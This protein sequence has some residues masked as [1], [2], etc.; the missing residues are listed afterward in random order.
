MCGTLPVRPAPA[1]PIPEEDGDMDIE[2][3]RDEERVQLEQRLTLSVA[4]STGQ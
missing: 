3:L 1:G 4:G 2:G